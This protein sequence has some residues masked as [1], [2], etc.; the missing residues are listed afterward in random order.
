[1]D[2]RMDLELKGIQTGIHMLEIFSMGLKM[3]KPVCLF[4]VNTLSFFSIKVASKMVKYLVREFL[5]FEIRQK[6]KEYSKT[7]ISVNAFFKILNI[8]LWVNFRK[9]NYQTKPLLIFS[10]VNNVYRDNFNK[11]ALKENL[12]WEILKKEIINFMHLITD[13]L[14]RCRA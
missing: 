14:I 1:M 11:V 13:S 10:R 6:C 4:G 12:F 5:C 7:V 9:E 3:D 8:V 2:F